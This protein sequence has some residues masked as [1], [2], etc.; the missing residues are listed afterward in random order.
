MNLV[1]TRFALYSSRTSALGSNYTTQWVSLAGVHPLL[2]SVPPYSSSPLPSPSPISIYRFVALRPSPHWSLMRLADREMSRKISSWLPS[3]G[4]MH[5][6]ISGQ[7][8][9]GRLD[10]GF[11]QIREISRYEINAMAPMRSRL[12]WYW[13]KTQE[14]SGLASKP[15]IRLVPEIF[16]LCRNSGLSRYRKSMSGIR[17]SSTLLKC[18][19]QR[20]SS[21]SRQFSSASREL[22]ITSK[23]CLSGR[24]F[25]R[26]LV[27]MFWRLSP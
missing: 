14:L 13:Y 26:C 16:F 22:S 12:P 9:P 18:D 19:R 8:V 2:L 3:R 1:L 24:W 6:S 10:R 5:S 25:W 23:T 11:H 21:Q 7:L 17:Y 4:H 15:R 27:S 20:R